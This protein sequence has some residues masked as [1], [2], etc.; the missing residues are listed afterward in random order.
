MDANIVADRTKSQENDFQTCSYKNWTHTNT[1]LSE[2]RLS[3]VFDIWVSY[4]L[5]SY[6]SNVSDSVFYNIQAFI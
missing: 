3:R 4:M 1:K 6:E 2:A 5:C